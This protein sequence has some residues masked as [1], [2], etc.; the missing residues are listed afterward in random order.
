M[1]WAAH[2][3]WLRCLNIQAALVDW[4]LEFNISFLSM[5]KVVD[6][7]SFTWRY[8]FAIPWKEILGML[9]SE[10]NGMKILLTKIIG[11]K[12]SAGLHSWCK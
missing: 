9:F 12:W 8:M 7:L 5:T 2:I 3:S 4:N 10:E 6:L 11:V 1:N